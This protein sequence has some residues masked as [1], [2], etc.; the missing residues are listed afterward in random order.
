ME[1]NIKTFEDACQALGIETNLPVVEKLPAKHQAATI[2]MYKLGVIVESLN[3]GWKP[4]YNNR[5]EIKWE[6]WWQPVHKS[7]ND[8]SASGLSFYVAGSWRPTTVVGSRLCFK[9][10]ELCEYAAEQFLDL[11]EQA[12]MI[13]DQ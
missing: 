2:A 8:K 10:Q 9:S 11:Y 12:L 4:D 5:S 13:S 7:K 6:P 1:H 3:E